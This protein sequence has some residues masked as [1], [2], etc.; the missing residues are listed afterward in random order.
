M[1][2]ISIIILCIANVSINWILLLIYYCIDVQYTLSKTT[3]N[4]NYTYFIFIIKC[5]FF[6]Y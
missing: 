2:V 6:H 3:I 4:I 1:R 5:G